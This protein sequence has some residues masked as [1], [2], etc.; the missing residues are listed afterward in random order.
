MTQLRRYS[1][2][3]HPTTEIDP[4]SEKLFFYVR[5]TIDKVYKP[6]NT[7]CNMLS[8]LELVFL[9]CICSNYVLLFIVTHCEYM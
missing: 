2:P 5:N 7:N 4:V 3:F 9:L 1:L 6:R 8:P